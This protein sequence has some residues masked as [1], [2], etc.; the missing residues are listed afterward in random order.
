MSIKIKCPACQAKLKIDDRKAGQKISCP[1]CDAAFRVP[2][3]KLTPKT[4]KE[5]SKEASPDVVNK[6][7]EQEQL[8]LADREMT[9]EERSI[10]PTASFDIFEDD[11]DENEVENKD[12]FESSRLDDLFEDEDFETG[13]A[14][15]AS[16][17]DV[18]EEMVSQEPINEVIDEP[19]EDTDKALEDVEPE[20]ESND[21]FSDD[22]VNELRDIA[23]AKLQEALHK[24]RIKQ[25][26]QP[27]RKKD[28]EEED[29]DE[30]GFQLKPANSEFEEMDLTPMVDVT[31]LL[32]VF[33]MIT[34]SFSLQKSLE[35]PPPDPNEKGAS[36]APSLEDLEKESIM[37]EIDEEDQI[38]VDDE[39]LAD[40][41]D[42]ISRLEDVK[43]ED[44][45][46]REII[47]NANTKSRN[48]TLVFVIDAAN[49][50]KMQRIRLASSG[51]ETE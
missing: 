44:N 7:E 27:K 22:E 4:K 39:P 28:D 24:K 18:D 11:E 45:L 19:T 35:V 32:L 25:R 20:L 21:D 9:A 6:N 14:E 31:F 8:D 41:S 49:D 2:K 5:T 40:P 48:E 34:A 23:E 50:V 36:S 43:R 12:N 15:Q 47:I 26:N 10:A 33:F 3:K 29:D 37:V 1:T 16:G 46:K 38:I 13:D 17:Q 51:D 30:D 42:L